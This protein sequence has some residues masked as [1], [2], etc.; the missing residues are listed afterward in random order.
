MDIASDLAIEPGPN[1]AAY[2]ASKHALAGL[3]KTL[4]EEV[5]EDGIQVTTVYPGAADTE[6]HDAHGQSR[7]GFM[8]AGEVARSIVAVLSASGDTVRIKELHLQPA[9]VVE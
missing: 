8:D 9:R 1:A 3:S 7:K 5:R 2:A 6:I 4:A